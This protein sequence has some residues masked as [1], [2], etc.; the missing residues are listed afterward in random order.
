MFCFVCDHALTFGQIMKHLSTL[1][2]L[3]KGPQQD[4]MQF[5][6]FHNFQIDKANGIK[7]KVFNFAFEFF[8]H[9]WVLLKS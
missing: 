7:I 9:N 2:V 1:M 6:W 4:G 8:F 3:S 5:F